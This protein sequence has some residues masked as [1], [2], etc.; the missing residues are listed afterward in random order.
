MKLV[1][2]NLPLTIPI[3]NTVCVCQYSLRLCSAGGVW[4]GGGGGGGGGV[5]ALFIVHVVSAWL[6]KPDRCNL[7]YVQ[8]TVVFGDIQDSHV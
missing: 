3:L 7:K 5:K 1:T 6:L 8:S 4:V 2:D